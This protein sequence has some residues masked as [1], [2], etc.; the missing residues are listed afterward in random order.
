MQAQIAVGSAPAAIGSPPRP[1]NRDGNSQYVAASTGPM[2]HP[3][4]LETHQAQRWWWLREGFGQARLD[5]PFAGGRIQR[6]PYPAR[7]PA[8]AGVASWR[9][10]TA[11]IRLLAEL[12]KPNA[13]AS[14]LT[15]SSD[16]AKMLR[17]RGPLSQPS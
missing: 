11:L 3:Q 12:R 7:Q 8:S 4:P 9:P 1:M 13:T 15:V 2:G 10:P 16:Q 6:L 5:R 17:L 14:Q